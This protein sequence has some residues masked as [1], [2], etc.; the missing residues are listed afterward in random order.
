[1]S[2]VRGETQLSYLSFWSQFRYDSRKEFDSYGLVG[3]YQNQNKGFC[4][5]P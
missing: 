1:M 3:A 5:I 4:Q 2:D